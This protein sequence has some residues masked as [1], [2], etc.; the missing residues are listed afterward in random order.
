MTVWVLQF[1]VAAWIRTGWADSIVN[2][3]VR[4]SLRPR[5]VRVA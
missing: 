1:D 2:P 4:P 3:D 5:L